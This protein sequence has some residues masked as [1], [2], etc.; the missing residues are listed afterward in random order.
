M[1]KLKLLIELDYNAAMMHE[2]DPEAIE[3]FFTDLLPG[4]ELFL[5]SNEIGDTVGTV[6]VMDI[7]PEEE[8]YER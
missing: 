2:N 8:N 6:R 1:A 3:W 4:D 7:L 5:H